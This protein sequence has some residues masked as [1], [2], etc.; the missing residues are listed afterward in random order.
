MEIL[1]TGEFDKDL[2]KANKEEVKRIRTL[3]ELLKAAGIMGKQLH[4]VKNTYS[5]RIGNKRL[6]YRVEKSKVTL[7]FFKSRENIYDYLR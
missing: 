2:K 7:L 1:S 6:V 4:H 3:I 5:V